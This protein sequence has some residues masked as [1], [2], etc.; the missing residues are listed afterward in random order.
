MKQDWIDPVSG[1][2][3]RIECFAGERRTGV[4]AGFL[5]KRAEKTYLVTNWHVATGRDANHPTIS[6]D[7]SFT[8]HIRVHFLERTGDKIFL[9]NK[10]FLD[11]P[12]NDAAGKGLGWFQHPILKNGID[13]AAVPI[14]SPSSSANRC[15]N[16]NNFFDRF[17]LAIS[18]D[19]FVLG[20]PWGVGGAV[21][22][23]PVWKGG[24]VASIPGLPY[25]NKPCFL[26]DVNTFKGM[27]GGPVICQFQLGLQTNRIHNHQKEKDPVIGTIQ[28]F[29]GVYSGR[30][31]IKNADGRETE[32]DLGYCWRPEL[33][34]QIIDLRSAGSAL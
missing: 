14:E 26:V 8:S 32:T 5:Y 24:T 17:I 33:I 19:I 27:S 25:N 18:D 34:D 28:Y 11:I 16:E 23:L 31:R 3:V 21:D 4:A 30:A 13:V 12:M 15:L 22:T 6:A 2:V 10:L 1:S 20:F 29:C 9:T 7:G